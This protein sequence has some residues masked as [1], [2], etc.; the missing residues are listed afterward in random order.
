MRPLNA[1][2][3]AP[4]HTS[5]SFNCIAVELL[6]WAPGEAML[7]ILR[8]KHTCTRASSMSRID[9][10]FSGTACHWSSAVIKAYH[11]A[12]STALGGLPVND[13]LL[14][15]QLTDTDTLWITWSPSKLAD[16]TETPRSSWC[17]RLMKDTQKWATG[18]WNAVALLA[19]FLFNMEYFCLPVQI[20]A[21]SSHK[22][23]EPDLLII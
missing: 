5:H 13:S 2:C 10:L 15:W 12:L 9:L 14:A 22:L 7:K 19:Y 18:H 4:K 16:L 3:A 17:P 20:L 11:R 8:H 6:K 23:I 1:I 21:S